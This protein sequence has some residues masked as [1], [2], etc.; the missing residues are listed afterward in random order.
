MTPSFKI[1]LDAKPTGGPGIFLTRLQ[2][3]LEALGCFD[4]DHPDVWIQLSHE[5]VPEAIQSN[6]NVKRLVRT[7]GGYYYRHYFME[8][9][10]KIP[11][12]W[13][14]TRI[15][16]EQNDKRN[17][18][19]RQNL[20][21]ADGIV[22]QS[23]FARTMTHRFITTTEPGHIIYNGVDISQ[24]SPPIVRNRDPKHVN[25]MISHAFRPHKRLHEAIRFI[26]ALQQASPHV[27]I[28]LHVLGGD[29]GRCFSHAETLIERYK[30][31]NNV[32]FWGKQ[33]FHQLYELYQSCDFLLAVPIWDP[34]PNV[35]VEALSC[36][37][38]VLGTTSGGIPELVQ[39][40]G[41]LIPERIPLTYLDH[42]DVRF[43]PRIN[44]GK[45]V[46]EALYLLDH[47]EEYRE[48]ARQRA[49]E[50]LDIRNTAKQYWHACEELLTKAPIQVH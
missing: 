12:P 25:I 49:I 3:E 50:S 44:V 40:A 24:F 7:A 22:Y 29:D 45:Y 20:V 46:Q 34:C 23:V 30:L 10:V 1:G 13:I 27:F 28:Q 31:G 48:K 26:H 43:M 32:R 17:R 37:L 39:D 16:R 2:A 8:K 21:E 5:K 38:P 33:P 42:H 11:L 4:K 14:D 36:G 9:P 35:I 6:P 15:S 19:I 18:T 41:R 47:L